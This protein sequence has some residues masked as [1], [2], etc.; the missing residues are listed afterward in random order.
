MKQFFLIALLCVLTLG[1]CA[2]SMCA[3][4]QQ[5]NPTTMPATTPAVT[6]PTTMPEPS[7]VVTMPTVDSNIPDPDVDT[8]H[9]DMEDIL[10]TDGNTD[11]TAP[12]DTVPDSTET[13]QQRSRYN[14]RGY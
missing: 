2:C 5:T 1:L 11:S 7:S 3:A 6:T 13:Q 9:A 8:S 4:P 10:P 14:R 12:A